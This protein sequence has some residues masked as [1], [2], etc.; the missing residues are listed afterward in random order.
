MRPIG[1]EHSLKLE[2]VARAEVR[3]A[4][5]YWWRDW[6]SATRLRTHQAGRKPLIFKRNASFFAA[7]GR[8]APGALCMND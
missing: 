5:W 7:A 8:Q 6:Y 1:K 4:G 2:S 3:R